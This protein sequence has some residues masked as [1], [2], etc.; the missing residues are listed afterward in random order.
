MKVLIKGAGDLATGIA[1]KLSACDCQ[2]IMTEREVPLT[3]RRSVAL[4]RAIY[5]DEVQVEN[6]R[7]IRVYNI[8][9]AKKVLAAGDIAVIADEEATISWEYQPEVIVDAIMAKRNTGTA[10]TDAPFVIGVGPGFCGGKDCHCV[11][12]TKR[13][14]SLGQI[15]WE[16]SA[17]PNTGVPGNVGGYTIERLIKAEA[18]GVIEPCVTIGTVVEKGQMVA[19]TGNVP[20]YAK[21]SGIVRGM[22]QPGVRV[23]KGLKIGDIDARATRELCDTISDKARIIGD[24][25][26]KAIRTYDKNAKC[27]TEM[28]IDRTAQKQEKTA[29]YAIVLLAAGGSRRFG[30]NKLLA[31]IDSRP[32]YQHM[33]EKLKK[34]ADVPRF[35]VTRYPQIA[36]EAEEAGIHVVENWH[37]DRGI[38]YSV[39]LGLE[40]CLKRNPGLKGV[41]F[42]V[43]DQPDIRYQTME[44]LIETAGNNLGKIVCVGRDGQPGNPVVWDRRYFPDL[45]SLT[46]DVG[47]RQVMRRY[48]QEIMMLEALEEELRDIDFQSDLK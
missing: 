21:M 1:S 40:A 36:A 35:V 18:D 28:G 43:C 14:R 10:M 30:D 22:L 5:E 47:G 48:P 17:I 45:L 11:I 37:L 46:G 13:G 24:G 33:L 12:E 39:R 32:M 2:I 4:S 42:T 31:E 9:E 6:M 29:D 27:V 15:I 16:G 8:E 25:V 20:V 3:V 34:F 23:K 26:V 44:R 38:S 7:G 19:R 41:L